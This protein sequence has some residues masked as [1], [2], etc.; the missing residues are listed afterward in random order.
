MIAWFGR[1]L[2][3]LALLWASLLCTMMLVLGMPAQ[4]A[5]AA[6]NGVNVILMIGDGMGWEMARAAAIAKGTPLYKS[7]KGED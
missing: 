6:G 7:G 2:R 4:S 5:I 1:H 3:W